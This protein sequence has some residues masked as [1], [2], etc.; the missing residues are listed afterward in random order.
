ME[1]TEGKHAHSATVTECN[2]VTSGS[3]RNHKTNTDVLAQTNKP[4]SGGHHSLHL[5][6]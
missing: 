5:Q 4:V 2:V 6:H 1:L 3:T